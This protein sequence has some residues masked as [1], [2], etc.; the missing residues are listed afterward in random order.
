MAP[1]FEKHLSPGVYSYRLKKNPKKGQLFAEGDALDIPFLRKAFISREIDPFEP[2][3]GL[4]PKFEK[5]SRDATLSGY[6]Y[7]SVSDIAGYFE[8]I[9]HVLIADAIQNILPDEPKILNFIT[10]L[11]RCYTVQSDHGFRPKRGIPQGSG[12][13]SFLGN[14]FLM[15]VDSYFTNFKLTND[16]L[17]YRYMDDIRIFSK[18]ITVARKVIFEL[19]T[20]IRKLHLNVQTAKTV[21]LDE[22]KKEISNSLFDE[23]SEQIKSIREDFTR[24]PPSLDRDTSIRR[25]RAIARR[26][27]TNTT[28]QPFIARKTNDK[29]DLTLRSMRMWMNTNLILKDDDHIIQLYR[30]IR[31][32][33]DPRLMKIFI[34]NTKVFPRKKS[35]QRSILNFLKS[36]FNIFPYQEAQFIN[37][38]R[39]FSKVDVDLQVRA[40]EHVLG[41][42]DLPL[43]IECLV[44]CGRLSLSIAELKKLWVRFEKEDSWLALPY[45][46]FALSQWS[47]SQ[48]DTMVSVLGHHP[49]PGVAVVGNFMRN[50][51]E[52]GRAAKRFLKFVFEP[53]RWTRINDWIGLLWLV[54]GSPNRATLT[55]LRKLIA[56]SQQKHPCMQ[57]REVLQ[58]IDHRTEQKISSLPT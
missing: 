38:L 15:P 53:N 17:Y 18:D 3:Y 44:L 43:K 37:G 25:L 45:Y 6:R 13:F 33:S 2:W 57:I 24:N 34:G 35:W 31:T 32:N 51:R 16:I 46:A 30:L 50:I 40:K 39:Y 56:D 4:W 8:N 42:S 11:L 54:S 5:A 27:P 58:T 22:N 48:Q 36:E 20:Q 29:S 19:E 41:D 14:I 9:S 28:C 52:D 47:G 12:I 1:H 26:N 7:L 49:H 55:L 10:E 23:R 21:I